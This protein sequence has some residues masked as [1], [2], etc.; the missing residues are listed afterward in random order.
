MDSGSATASADHE[1]QLSKRQKSNEG[2]DM[3]SNLPDFIIGRILSLLPTKE[4]VRT[5]VLSK[6]WIYLWTF[7]TKLC[8]KDKEHYSSKKIRKTCFC[9]FVHDVLHHLNSSSIQSLTLTISEEYDPSHINEWISAV[10]NRRVKKLCVYS[11]KDLNLSS[12][13]I[14]ECQSLEKLD[15]TMAWMVCCVIRVPT[16]V[17]LSSLTV[18]KFSGIRFTCYFSNDLKNLTLNFPILRKFETINCNWSGVKCVTFEVPL[19]EV[20]TIYYSPSECLLPSDESHTEIKF[21]ASR[22]AQFTYDGYMLPVTILL[23]I[24]TAQIS[25]TITPY[26]YMQQSVKEMGILACKLLKQF[27]NNVECLTFHQSRVL[28]QAKDS[29]A[30]LPAFGMLSHLELTIV[31][32]EIL[33]ELLLKTPF[34][35]TLVLSVSYC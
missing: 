1:N 29:L 28:L 33:L 17:F 4:A 31:T 10:L 14:F 3:I 16:F 35:K 26:R 25:A 5:S 13:N 22:L 20:V 12:L 9:N 8:F 11:Q 7:I 6:R 15:L 27:N 30:A 18:L 21:C 2:K 23:D 34:L 19:L 32:G 24:S